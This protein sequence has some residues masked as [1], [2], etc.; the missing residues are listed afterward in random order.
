MPRWLGP[1]CVAL[2][3]YGLYN[4]WTERSLRQP[5]GILAPNEPI[6]RT[7][8]ATTGPFARAGWMM[9]PLAEFTVEARVLARERY[10]WD[11]TASLAPIDLALGWGPLSDSALLK[12][13]SFDQHTRFLHWRMNDSAISP[14]TLVAH[15]ANMHMIPADAAIK[16]A[17]IAARPGQIARFSGYLVSATNPGAGGEWRSSLS[18]TDAGAGACE[19]VW[20]TAF[21]A[22]NR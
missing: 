8:T 6:Q 2:T 9:M 19:I 4:V 12:G 17:L 10:R 21:A 16:H 22:S 14:A 3:C 15:T 11:A 5:P 18:R 20:V 13:L 7:L 1:L